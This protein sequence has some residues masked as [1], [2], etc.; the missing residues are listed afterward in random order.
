MNTSAIVMMIVA[1]LLIWG[2][3]GVARPVSRLNP[4]GRWISGSPE[5]RKARCPYGRPGRLPEGHALR[6]DPAGSEEPANGGQGPQGPG[7]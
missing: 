4:R 3:L 5:E 6:R 1:I 2:G 7:G